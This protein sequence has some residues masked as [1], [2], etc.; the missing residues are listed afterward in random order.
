M[1]TRADL[2][3]AAT[4][5]ACERFRLKHRRWPGELAELAHAFMSPVPLSPFDGQPLRYRVLPD[6]IAVYSFWANAPLKQDL[7]DGFQE[8]DAAGTGI[9]YRAWKPDRRAQPERPEDKNDP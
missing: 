1:R 5:I 8:G 3:A 4:C 2:L 9:G 6:R 7:P